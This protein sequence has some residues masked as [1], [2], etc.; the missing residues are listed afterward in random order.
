MKTILFIFLLFSPLVFSQDKTS[1]PPGPTNSETPN[2]ATE[3][4]KEA[5]KKIEKNFLKLIKHQQKKCGFANNFQHQ[6]NLISLYLNSF[7]KD[8][9][10][11]SSSACENGCHK[12]KHHPD[13]TCLF[14]N[15]SILIELDYLVESPGFYSVY[16]ERGFTI[17]MYMQ[18]TTYFRQLLQDYAH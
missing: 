12:L 2:G 11:I 6:D 16:N 4:D 15:K 7:Y 3:K 14:N 9:A 8:E 18:I 10:N 17:E 1:I 5:F 13:V